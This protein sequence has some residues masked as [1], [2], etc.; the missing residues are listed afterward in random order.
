M[1]TRFAYRTRTVKR[2]F[3]P[4]TDGGPNVVFEGPGRD[5]KAFPPPTFLVP[6]LIAL[7]EEVNGSGAAT[8][9]SFCYQTRR[10]LVSDFHGDAK[11]SGWGRMEN[12]CT[13]T[14][15]HFLQTMVWYRLIRTGG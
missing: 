9:E 11:G 6:S 8:F 2:F 4:P 3:E 1:G 5:N 13:L 12:E 14:F 10:G 15:S 7:E